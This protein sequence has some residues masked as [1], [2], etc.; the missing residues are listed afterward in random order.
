MS[1]EAFEPVTKKRAA[2]VL[3]VSS[4]TVDYWVEQGLMP[5]PAHIGRHCYWHP[6]TFYSWLR[7]RLSCPSGD[8]SVESS[9]EPQLSPA[10]LGLSDSRAREAHANA[11]TPRPIA[12]RQKRASADPLGKQRARVAA[13]NDN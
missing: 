4:R 8:D 5:A 2:E 11:Q 12:A 6:D 7:S 10:D 13:L 9:P 3:Q 1:V